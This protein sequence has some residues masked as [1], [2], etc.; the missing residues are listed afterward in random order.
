MGA[1]VNIEWVRVGEYLPVDRAFVLGAAT[2]RYPDVHQDNPADR[3]GQDFWLVL[4]MSFHVLHRSEDTGVD[5]HNCFVDID[6]VVRMPHGKTA[7]PETITHW[8][9][10]PNL[11]GT[12]ATWLLG[13]EVPA[14]RTS[15]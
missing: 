9:Y 11:P 15:Y 13:A 10:L 14:L 1:E 4:P 3:P 6:D 12:A 5:Y 7:T 2:G 8:T